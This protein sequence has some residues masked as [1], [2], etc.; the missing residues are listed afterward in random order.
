M[1]NR[2]KREK[3]IEDWARETVEKVVNGTYVYK[4][5]DKPAVKKGIRCFTALFIILTVCLSMLPQGPV[6]SYNDSDFDKTKYSGDVTGSGTYP[7]H[8]EI[9]SQ[10]ALDSTDIPALMNIKGTTYQF[11]CELYVD[12][13]MIVYGEP[14]GTFKAVSGG[15]FT[16]GGKAGEYRYLGY[17]IDGVVFSNKDFPDDAFDD[18]RTLA[19]RDWQK[20]PWKKDYSGVSSYASAYTIYN[21][22]DDSGGLSAQLGKFQADNGKGTVA[23]ALSSKTPFLDY[24]VIQDRPDLFQQGSFRMWHKAGTKYWYQTFNGQLDIKPLNPDY[25]GSLS[26]PDG[27]SFTLEPDKNEVT[28][29]VTVSGNLVD[30]NI[31]SN[32]YRKVTTYYRDN[33]SSYSIEL[34][35][36]P[37]GVKLTASDSDLTKTSNSTQV[38]VNKI[39]S[40]TLKRHQLSAGVN[41]IS[42][43]GIPRVTYKNNKS[44]DM[45][46]GS[47]TV[48]INVK[49]GGSPYVTLTATPNPAEVKFS[50]ADIPVAVTLNSKLEGVSDTSGISGIS[51]SCRKKGETTWQQVSTTAKQLTYSNTFNFTIPKA[52]ITG[53]NYSQVFEGKVK[54]TVY[55]KEY[56]TT[57]DCMTYVFKQTP[58]PPEPVGEGPEAKLGVPTIAW[59]GE[60]FRLSDAGSSDPDGSIVEYEFYYQCESPKFGGPLGDIVGPLKPKSGEKFVNVTV[61]TAGMYRAWLIVTDNNGNSGQDTKQFEVKV[62]EPQAGITYTGDLKVNRPVNISALGSFSPARFPIIWADTQW[63]I[64]PPEG[65]AASDIKYL[66]TLNGSST[67]DVLFKKPGQY[68]LN[69]TVNNGRYSNSTSM[70][71]EIAP[72]E[73]PVAYFTAPVKAFR[74]PDNEN[75]VIVNITDMSCATDGDMLGSYDYTV[76]Y[77]SDN[78]SGNGISDNSA[79]NDET[80]VPLDSFNSVTGAGSF[81]TDKIGKYLITA[82]VKESFNPGPLSVFV[83]PWEYLQSNP[84]T[85]VVEVDNYAPTV[86]LKASK[87]SKVD[88]VLNIGNIPQEDKDYLNDNIENL[89]DELRANFVD[90]NITVS[91]WDKASQPNYLKDSSDKLSSKVWRDG[92]EKKYFIAATD[93][94]SDMGDAPPASPIQRLNL[95]QIPVTSAPITGTVD[96]MAAWGDMLYAVVGVASGDNTEF[97]LKHINLTSKT[98]TDRS[99]GCVDRPSGEPY[100]SPSKIQ[101]DR[102]GNPYF[103]IRSEDSSTVDDPFRSYF[104]LYRGGGIITFDSFSNYNSTYSDLG[105]DNSGRVTIWSASILSDIS[106]Y[107][108]C[109]NYWRTSSNWNPA[110]YGD[111]SSNRRDTVDKI[112]YDSSNNEYAIGRYG[113]TSSSYPSLRINRGSVQTFSEYKYVLLSY[114]S[115]NNLILYACDESYNVFKV[116]VTSAGACSAQPVNMPGYNGSVFKHDTSGNKLYYTSAVGSETKIYEYDLSTDK[117][118]WVRTYD[119]GVTLWDVHQY[120]GEAEFFFTVGAVPMIYRSRH[121]DT[122]P[123]GTNDL[124]AYIGN[125]INKNGYSAY[126]STAGVCGY[127]YIQADKYSPDGARST[128]FIECPLNQYYQSVCTVDLNNNLAVL[129]Y[130]T[131]GDTK[132]YMALESEGFALRE[133]GLSYSPYGTDTFQF[134]VHDDNTISII[135]NG[136]TSYTR[137]VYNR[138]TTA[139]STRGSSYCSSVD[140]CRVFVRNDIVYALF[141]SSISNKAVFYVDNGARVYTL[142]LGTSN[143]VYSA[144]NV[145]VDSSGYFYLCYT[146]GMISGSRTYYYYRMLSD[147]P[148]YSPFNYS[149][150]YFTGGS[151]VLNYINLNVIDDI[152]YL[153]YTSSGS[154]GVYRV[155]TDGTTSL[156]HYILNISN[157]GALKIIDGS[158]YMYMDGATTCPLACS[159]V[160]S[161]VATGQGDN[162]GAYYDWLI[163]D[164]TS[165]THSE[166]GQTY[167]AMYNTVY[168]RNSDSFHRVFYGYSFGTVHMFFKSGGSYVRKIHS[169]DTASYELASRKG[170]AYGNDKMYFLEQSRTNYTVNIRSIGAS[171]STLVYTIPVPSGVSPDGLSLSHMNLLIDESGYVYVSYYCGGYDGVYRR[172]VTTNRSGTWTTVQVGAG[173]QWGNQYCGLLSGDTY[174]TKDK[175]VFLPSSIDGTYTCVNYISLSN[176]SGSVGSWDYYAGSSNSNYRGCSTFGIVDMGSDPPLIKGLYSDNDGKQQ[177]VVFSTSKKVMNEPTDMYSNAKYLYVL[178]SYDSSYYSSATTHYYILDKTTLKVINYKQE[179]SLSLAIK[180]NPGLVIGC[181][182]T[183]K[184]LTVNDY[185]SDF[186]AL[187]PELSYVLKAQSIVPVFLTRMVS[188]TIMDLT[189]DYGGEVIST[190]GGMNAALS[191]LKYK[192]LNDLGK[193]GQNAEDFY[194][195]EYSEDGTPV[196]IAVEYDPWFFDMEGDPILQDKW[197]VT[198]D[199]AVYLNN[200]GRIT[201]SGSENLSIPG[202]LPP[203]IATNITKVGKYTVEYF[204]RDYPSP[205]NRF[206]NYRK[207]SAGTEQSKKV[208]YAHRRP[209][210]IFT[211]T[212]VYDSAT[213]SYTMTYNDMSYDDDHYQPGNPAS[214]VDKGIIAWE[215]A[216]KVESAVDWIP[217]RPAALK[218]G[219]T[220]RI[221]LRVR[222]ID[223]PNGLGAWSDVF[224]FRYNA[225]GDPTPPTV[226]ANPTEANRTTDIPVTITATDGGGSGLNRVMY[227]WTTTTAKPTTGWIRRSI[228]APGM[229][230]YSFVTT[231]TTAGTYYLHMEAFDNAGNSF[232][233]WRG[234]YTRQGNEAPTV[235]ISISP[236]TVYESDNVTVT[237]TP[238][239][240]D[241]DTADLVLRQNFNNTGWNSV[242][243]QNSAA[244]GV[245]QT[246][247]I[248]DVSS[249]N[250]QLSVTATDPEGRSGSATISFSANTLDITG[251]V[252]HTNLWNKHRIDYNRA[253]TGSDDNPRTYDVFFPGEMFMLSASTTAIDASRPGLTCSSVRCDIVSTSFNDILSSGAGNTWLGDIWDDSMLKWDSR[254]LIFRFT[255]IYSNG[256][257]VT[258]DVTVN[259]DDDQY[260]RL[261]RTF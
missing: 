244:S 253:K 62:E 141:A 53:E 39:F 195:I 101:V 234:P 95:S 28:F 25:N 164:S 250:Y 30:G 235:T 11:N 159:A 167:Y 100:D 44:F 239:D 211:A 249:G 131:S 3:Y 70:N 224:E 78:D 83:N 96:S 9:C 85:A 58:P 194:T 43:K 130:A 186:I 56:I 119:R 93:S 215:W 52:Q 33:V 251:M 126:S 231:L 158:D 196:P 216:W 104:K 162:L 107:E 174:L 193:L 110:S 220:Y 202:Q 116:T 112:L 248:N 242:Y 69:L 200:T 36:N 34:G 37:G 238:T 50:N 221:S 64:V 201:G 149:T 137:R 160:V 129:F 175:L 247:V 182:S 114:T 46:S 203:A 88:A 133:T 86:G 68:T 94:V 218:A 214:R 210:A 146:E 245:S 35:A 230:S 26:F 111:T 55:N 120:E 40:I 19:Q 1:R 41:S 127:N 183:E 4:Y 66:G 233:R 74:D 109:A 254:I 90:A 225:I 72:D 6:M 65:A 156:N 16:S 2:E 139:F 124:T 76:R 246:Y 7:N 232:Y 15:Y 144:G 198:H 98:V 187:S 113:S 18:S 54:Y 24:G 108:Q 199:E 229:N 190:I 82:T 20:M 184:Y 165:S 185:F 153:Y 145:D 102:Y 45:F 161:S 60:P 166:A 257:A 255:A 105:I 142:P 23:A 73:A 206:D 42:V 207:W 136:R 103:F 138:D 10:N 157:V 29:R 169:Y 192:I 79:F 92:I 152:P 57:A 143:R 181:N 121:N 197:K 123:T 106:Y 77:D 81:T 84:Y 8:G 135:G 49:A 13:K 258:H 189:S 170:F 27:K 178:S 71:I 63:S 222:D 188:P 227:H 128:F 97:T 219:N 87:V 168:D 122:R 150:Y 177:K 259:I 67:K 155:H 115:G 209:H 243:S 176:L 75:K 179:Y 80:A 212:G 61:D 148:A 125:T 21:Q 132:V 240:P 205:D 38:S 91:Q 140:Y 213:S 208:F 17:T 14:H 228:T 180:K 47:D 173:I 89:R 147:N 154:S 191:D 12:K 22:S 256:A 252:S 151:S 118:N 32:P 172:Y 31:L 226:D 99:T 236:T 237:I 48:T 163:K 117:V 5:L 134:Y 260:W 51:L 204:V 59:V 217:G 223:G 241:G 171:S 261:R